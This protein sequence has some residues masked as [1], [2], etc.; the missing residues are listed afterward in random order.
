MTHLFCKPVHFCR[1]FF[2]YCKILN[3]CHINDGNST[4]F[5]I[6]DTDSDLSSNGSHLLADYQRLERACLKPEITPE[7]EAGLSIF[8]V[9][10]LKFSLRNVRI[11]G[12]VECNMKIKKISV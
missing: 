12:I 6:L 9:M 4:C 1:V 11:N 2:L 10:N 3:F 8:V 5:I 7:I